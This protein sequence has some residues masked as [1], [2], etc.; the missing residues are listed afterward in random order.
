M[1]YR[2]RHK[3]GRGDPHSSGVWV[4]AD[5]GYQTLKAEDIELEPLGSW[6]SPDSG[7]SYP[8]PWRL[9]LAHEDLELKITPLLPDQELRVSVRYWEGAVTVTGQQAKSV[10]KGRGYLEMTRYQ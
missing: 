3:D 6:T 5:G 10:I 8:M 2:L 7:D 9:R 4:A 1:Y